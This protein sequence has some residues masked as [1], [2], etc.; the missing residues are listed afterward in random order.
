M[1]LIAR[2]TAMAVSTAAHADFASLVELGPNGQP[3]AR[4][5]TTVAAWKPD[6]V[7]HVGDYL[8]RETECPTDQP[9]CAGAPWGYGWDS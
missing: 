7:V 2:L 8:Y 3:V 1:R 5:I 9:G 4:V 6:A